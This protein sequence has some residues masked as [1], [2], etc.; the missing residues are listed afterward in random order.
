MVL[1]VWRKVLDYRNRNS[2]C[3]YFYG[4]ELLKCASRKS[5]KHNLQFFFSKGISDETGQRSHSTTELQ[6]G[7]NMT[8]TNCD[9]FTHK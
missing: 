3:R 9:L 8:G 6:G 4:K 2:K 7:S 5:E 1:R